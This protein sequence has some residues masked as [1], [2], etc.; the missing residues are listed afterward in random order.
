MEVKFDKFGIYNINVDYLKYLHDNVDAEVYYSSSKYEK[1]PF[2][3]LVVGIGSYMYFIPFTS[4][5]PK[6]LN[7]KN[8]APDH[9]IIYETVEKD[10]LS[11][12]A[13]YKAISEDLV[14]HI[15]AVLD[16]KKMIPV[17]N[18]AYSKIE[19]SDVQDYKY[20]AL[21]EKE[22]RFCQGIQE[23]ILDRVH[24]IY[25]NQKRTGVVRRFYCNFTALEKG[26]EEYGETK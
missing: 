14:K 18:G 4:C 12:N 2:L 3:G 19:F 25:D 16:M 10:K 7:W 1:K 24:K 8:V 6:H 9:Y 26:C 15:L 22:Y 5:K 17:P 13:I 20:R 11:G 23:G 21:L